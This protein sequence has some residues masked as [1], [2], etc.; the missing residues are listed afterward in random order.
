[1]KALL[2]TQRGWL[3]TEM[4]PGYA[5]DLNPVELLWGNVKEQ[6]LANLIGQ[7]AYEAAYAKRRLA[8]VNEAARTLGYVLSPFPKPSAPLNVV[9]G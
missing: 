6:E 4:L 2:S 8:A 3:K 1:M 7:A 5:P 9:L